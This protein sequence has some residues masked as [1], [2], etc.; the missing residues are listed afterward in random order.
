VQRYLLSRPRATQI[1]EILGQ[2]LMEME[3][4]PSDTVF[5]SMPQRV[6]AT[7]AGQQRGL[8]VGPRT[9]QGRAHPRAARRPGRQFPRPA[10]KVVGELDDRGLIR[11]VRGK[12]TILDPAGI[13]LKPRTD[14]SNADAAGCPYGPLA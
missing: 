12:I 9:A 8:G 1:T 10:A 6:T 5:K 13:W 11:L 2:R 3:R 14:A 7:L 4:R